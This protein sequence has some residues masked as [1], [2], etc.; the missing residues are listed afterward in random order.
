MMISLLFFFL[1]GGGL[2]MSCFDWKL[3]ASMFPI[4]TVLTPRSLSNATSAKS[5]TFSS[6][7]KQYHVLSHL[8]ME[9]VD[10]SMGTSMG[11]I[12]G[13]DNAVQPPKLKA[14]ARTRLGDNYVLY[15]HYLNVFRDIM[16]GAAHDMVQ[17]QGYTNE[18]SERK[19]P[20][21]LT[22]IR[23]PTDSATIDIEFS[24][25]VPWET[26]FANCER[27][28]VPETNNSDRNLSK[29]DSSLSA[30]S[31]SGIGAIDL[32]GWMNFASEK[33]EQPMNAL[34]ENMT[35]GTGGQGSNLIGWE[36]EKVSMEKRIHELEVANEKLRKQNSV[37]Q[38]AVTDKLFTEK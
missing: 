10:C 9:Q 7:W 26:L 34:K 24:L 16:L 19:V 35:A 11:S 1:I 13:G 27:T 31:N 17:L 18:D 30:G 29:A 33:V 14:E 12:S 5:R 22:T 38:E 2:D 25:F 37:L 4:S 36:T 15:P 6:L 32:F 20:R 3:T 21:Q 8:W 28:A 23:M